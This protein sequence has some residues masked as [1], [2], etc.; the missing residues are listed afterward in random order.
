MNKHTSGSQE[1]AAFAEKKVTWL[2]L[3]YDLAFCSGSFKGESCFITCRKWFN[4]S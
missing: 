1:I 2:E 3:F 4:S